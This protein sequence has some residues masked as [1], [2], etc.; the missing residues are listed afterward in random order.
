MEGKDWVV[1][2]HWAGSSY[3][4]SIF[5]GLIRVVCACEVAWD[6]VQTL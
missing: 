3:Y 1:I 6:N 2:E 4:D 5:H